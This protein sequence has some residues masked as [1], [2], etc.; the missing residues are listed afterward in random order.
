MLKLVIICRYIVNSL[1]SLFYTS[2]T[3]NA[4]AQLL[5]INISKSFH[6]SKAIATLLLKHY[7]QL[8]DLQTPPL[9]PI[10]LPPFL[11]LTVFWPLLQIFCCSQY[12]FT[13]LQA[14]GGHNTS[15]SFP[16]WLSDGNGY[17]WLLSHG[18]TV[19]HTRHD[20]QGNIKTHYE[21]W[22]ILK[23]M[24]YNYAAGKGGGHCSYLD[25]HWRI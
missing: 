18:D 12:L 6:Y 14:S 24:L 5:K 4:A 25:T 11:S 7:W 22:L 1:F 2:S 10:C 3:L 15:S 16:Q 8:L 9:L 19:T 23:I 20:N 17:V 13:S 21:E